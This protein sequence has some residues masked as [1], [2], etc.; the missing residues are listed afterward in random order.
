M[1]VS[2]AIENLVPAFFFYPSILKLCLWNVKEI[3][4]WAFGKDIKGVVA[5][6]INL[7]RAFLYVDSQVGKSWKR[8]EEMQINGMLAESL[9]TS[10]DRWR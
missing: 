3:K 1:A 7:G 8:G 4:M 5:L 10:G 2:P 9:V 6:E